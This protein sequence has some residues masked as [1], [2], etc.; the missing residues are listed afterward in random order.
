MSIVRLG[1]VGAGGMARYH[2]G[3][4][5]KQ[6]D[7]TQVTAIC[8]PNGDNYEKAAEMFDKAGLPV[9]PCEASFDKFLKKHGKN[10]DAAFIVTPHNEHC[11]QAIALM[12][13]GIDVGAG[14]RRLAA[15]I[16]GDKRA[17]LGL[18][19]RYGQN[20]DL[21]LALVDKG[22]DLAERLAD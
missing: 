21:G 9:P 20:V 6:T 15:A 8:E 13:A 7:T 3:N 18:G 22:R 19:D 10:I 14:Y 5:L 4:I 12:E 16:D 1:L 11:P 17:T 2:I